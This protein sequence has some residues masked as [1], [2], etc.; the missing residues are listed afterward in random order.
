[1]GPPASTLTHLLQAR[2]SHERAKP[3]GALRR[4]PVRC[5]EVALVDH[6]HQQL[7]AAAAEPA[8]RGLVRDFPAPLASAVGALVAYEGRACQQALQDQL[9][10]YRTVAVMPQCSRPLLVFTIVKRIL[11]EE[12]GKVRTQCKATFICGLK[13]G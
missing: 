5:L 2:L 6:L 12:A 7:T 4:G 8:V 3:P 1:M 13:H 10:A 11:L 9:A